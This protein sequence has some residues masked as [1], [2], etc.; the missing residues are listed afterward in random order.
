MLDEI[1]ADELESNLKYFNVEDASTRTWGDRSPTILLFRKG[2]PYPYALYKY[3]NASSSWS[4]VC[5]AHETEMGRYICHSLEAD[6]WSYD[7]EGW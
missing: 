6:G 2:S 4:G 5:F 1:G 7:D 3:R